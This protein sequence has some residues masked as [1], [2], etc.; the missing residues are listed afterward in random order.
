MTEMLKITPSETEQFLI[1]KYGPGVAEVK[2]LG[3]GAWS[4]AFSFVHE[5]AKSVIRWSDMDDN[6][7]RDARASSFSCEGLPVP[8][9]T[10]L[11]RGINK[12]FAISPFIEGS[13]LETL[14]APDL[15]R[16][17]PSI[18]KM[19]RALRVVD[20]STTTGF[21][22]WNKEGKGSHDSW[23]EFLLDDK[24][25]SDGSLVKGWRENIR[26]F[27]IITD[28]YKNLWEKFES[29][30]EHCPSEKSL[31]HA[32]LINRNV[33]VADDNINAVLDWGSSF[34]GDSLYDVAWFTFYELW[35]SNFREIN[36]PQRLLKDYKT[37]PHT[38]KADLDLRLLCYQLHIAL[39][40]LAYN[41]F[42]QTWKNAQEVADYASKF[43][44]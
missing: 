33:L 23:K 14:P 26:N 43:L 40:S 3:A 10:E 34:Y 44:K 37:D 28:V 12:F 35:Y 18:L 38:N 11:G 32:D 31:V 27:P 21:G 41:S 1:D 29:L 39:D 7:E 22:Y 4:H 5:E 36:L 8:Q 19:L 13:F 16:T 9:I 42:K 24:N 15:D 17:T 25:E 30:V 6:F 20:L 2:Q